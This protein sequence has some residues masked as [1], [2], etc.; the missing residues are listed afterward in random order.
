MRTSRPFIN[1]RIGCCNIKPKKTAISNTPLQFAT[2][3]PSTPCTPSANDCEPAST[4][5]LPSSTMPSLLIAS[6]LLLPN[7][8]KHS[9]R[10]A[11]HDLPRLDQ[12][13]QSTPLSCL[14]WPAAPLPMPL[15]VLHRTG[16]GRCFFRDVCCNLH[17]CWEHQPNLINIHTIQVCPAQHTACHASSTSQR[18]A[19]P[20][21]VCCM[22]RGPP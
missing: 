11:P 5:T 10:H 18:T 14:Q 9:G 21:W 17:V 6:A 7:S 2:N 3:M 8:V 20:P 4:P 16:I 22:C 1:R 15:H 19:H 13:T 12:C